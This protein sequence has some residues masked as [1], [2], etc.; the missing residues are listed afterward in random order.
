MTI[1]FWNVDTQYD[2]MRDDE[3]YRGKLPVQGAKEIESTLEYI[4]R[5]AEQKDI[6]VIN[7]ADKHNDSTKEIS[8][9]PDLVNTFPEHCMEGTKGMEYVPAT[10]PKD[11]YVIDWKDDTFDKERV[12]GTRNIVIY[13]DKFSA[14]EGNPHTR[15]VLETINPDK[16]IV[17]G[18]ATNVCVNYAVQGL[19]DSGREV[20]VVTDAIKE[21]PN[22]P[23]EDTLGV[24]EEK[25][26]NMIS[27][28]DL[29]R[30]IE[31]YKDG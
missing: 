26:V 15:D 1:L 8:D 2:F 25:G 3:E 12:L 27:S 7:T 31:N 4:T 24:W 9:D 20:Y 21:L 19:A 17:Y 5:L 28:E 30:L 14:F 6:K 13:K 22:I 10:N 23:L 18:V 11:P 16:V 29:G